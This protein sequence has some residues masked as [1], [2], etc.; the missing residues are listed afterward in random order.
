MLDIKFVRDNPDAVKENIRTQGLWGKL[1][2]L[3]PD[4]VARK[5][6]NAV[7]K[8]RRSPVLGFWN[9]LMHAST[10]LLPLSWKMRFIA[11][12]WSKTRKDA[13]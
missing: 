5:S 12:K 6:L 4:V 7:R 8:N 13:F 2:A 10:A 11:K 9:K 3:P 1:A